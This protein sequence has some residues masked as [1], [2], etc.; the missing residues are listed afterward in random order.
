MTERPSDFDDRLLASE[1]VDPMRMERLRQQA[2][3]L[4]ERKLAPAARLICVLGGVALIVLMLA[5]LPGLRRR[6]DELPMMGYV[7]VIVG[8]ITLPTMGV[9]MIALG[10][11]GVLDARRHGKQFI[12]VSLLMC[13]GFG[14]GFLHS[15]WMSGDGQG[16]F[17]GAVLLLLGAGAFVMHVLEQYHMSTS[18]RLLE[19]QLAL[20]QLTEK[21]DQAQRRGAQERPSAGSQ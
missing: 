7:I 5:L 4:F 3:S 1:Q 8:L 16:V 17:A 15:G 14:G 18:K 11:G 21:F 6:W 20:A 10:R 9:I 12:A 13:F 19:V 2:A